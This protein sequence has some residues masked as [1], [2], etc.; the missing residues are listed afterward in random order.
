LPRKSLDTAD[1]SIALDI[2]IDENL[3]THFLML[4]EL[5]SV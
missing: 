1:T 2:K 3:M 5:H 4:I